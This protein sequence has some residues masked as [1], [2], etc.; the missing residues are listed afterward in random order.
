[1][2]QTIDINFIKENPQYFFSQLNENAEKE[3]VN[4]LSYF[5]FK[6]NII[7]DYEEKRKSEL[8]KKKDF[9]L[10]L[11]K[12]FFVSEEE[13]RNIEQTRK[14]INKWKVQEF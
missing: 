6:Y 5:I 14:E 3:L 11:K 7:V 9:L 2:L 8:K 12:G 10:F 4:L 13:I 1:M